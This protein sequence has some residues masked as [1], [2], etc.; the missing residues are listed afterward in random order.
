MMKK[1]IEELDLI[2][3]IIKY[4]VP[5][6]KVK[7]KQPGKLEAEVLKTQ[8]KV[9]NEFLDE[10]V[11]ALK[12]EE[13]K[14]EF[15]F[16]KVKE[17]EEIKEAF[18]FV[19]KYQDTEKEERVSVAVKDKGKKYSFEISKEKEKVEDKPYQLDILYENREG[20]ERLRINYELRDYPLEREQALQDFTNQLD[21]TLHIMP[22]S[23]MGGILGFTYLGENFMAR[24][25]DLTGAK[26]LMV[27]VHES[28]H[29]PDEYET[30]V[31]TDWMLKMER[32]RYKK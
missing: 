17:K 5:E 28:I 21:K 15:S 26:A 22:T 20:L 14:E 24:R 31:L 1:I 10:V 23:I 19:I 32:A 27:D 9:N 18:S 30:R 16:D 11:H 3:N 4:I 12:L 7:R 25:A 2:A 29:T 13:S 6:K 8:V